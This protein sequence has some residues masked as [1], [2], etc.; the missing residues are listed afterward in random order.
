[1]PPGFQA[2]AAQE[3]RIDEDEVRRAQGWAA[4]NGWHTVISSCRRW[5]SG[6]PSAGVELLAT[7]PG[8]S[9]AL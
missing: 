4:W 6:R 7:L 1:M 8:C 2:V 9:P 3:L 5:E